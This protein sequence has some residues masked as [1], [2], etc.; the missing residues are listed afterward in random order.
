V[1]FDDVALRE[2]VLLLDG[3]TAASG[4]GPASAPLR[5][6]IPRP[7]LWAPGDPFL[8]D[9]K[10]ALVRNGAVID[11][12]A[13]VPKYS[14][15]YVMVPVAADAARALKQGQNLIA[16]HCRQKEGAQAIDAGM[17]RMR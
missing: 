11:E 2:D 7:H 6:T 12:A 13:S 15:G 14:T 4:E 8:Y 16:V 10:V 9:L 3:L 17:V 5:L 1:E